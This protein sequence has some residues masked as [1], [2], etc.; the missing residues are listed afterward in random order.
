MMDTSE[1]NFDIMRLKNY[2]TR[3]TLSV[4]TSDKFFSFFYTV[5]LDDFSFDIFSFDLAGFCMEVDKLLVGRM[6][7]T[8]FDQEDR[9]KRIKIV[10]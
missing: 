3:V 9:R 1:D 7:D 8:V 2:V 5:P 6:A 10:I 4:E